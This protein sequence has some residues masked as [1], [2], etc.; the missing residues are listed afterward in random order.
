MRVEFQGLPRDKDIPGLVLKACDQP[1][2]TVRVSRAKFQPFFIRQVEE[3]SC[4]VQHVVDLHFWNSMILH[5][6]L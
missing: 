1:D 2:D 6:M 3:L 5:L 4:R